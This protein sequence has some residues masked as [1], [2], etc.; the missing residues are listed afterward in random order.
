MLC[1]PEAIQGGEKWNLRGRLF[2]DN[3]NHPEGEE[4]VLS[5]DDWAEMSLVLP[6]IMK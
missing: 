2:K 4:V 5:S 6:E 3:D 1:I